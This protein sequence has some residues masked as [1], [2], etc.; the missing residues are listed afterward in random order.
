MAV[1]GLQVMQMYGQIAGGAFMLY[2][3]GM[4]ALLVSEMLGE[5][6]AESRPA[7][8]RRCRKEFALKCIVR[9]A[10]RTPPGSL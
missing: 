10:C 9:P 8:E 1:P 3:A 7:H 6:R 4:S 5:F 2:I